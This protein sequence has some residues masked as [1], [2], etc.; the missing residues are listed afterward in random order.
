[1][2]ISKHMQPVEDLMDPAVQ[3]CPYSLYK[4]LRAEAPIYRMPDTG[5]Y[6]VTAF[7][8]CREIIRQ[9]DIFISGVTP[10]AL[11][12]EGIPAEVMDLR[13]RGLGAKSVLLHLGSAPSHLG[14]GT[15]VA[16]VYHGPGT[17]H[18]ALHRNY[19]APAY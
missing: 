15:T 7:D 14:A 1:M 19:S 5:F 16:N 13:D 11:K 3:A 6:L 12:S 2:A 17:C 10:L 4:Q 8:L 18:D 9:P